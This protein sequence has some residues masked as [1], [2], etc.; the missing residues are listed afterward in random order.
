MTWD[1]NM[2]SLSMHTW[3]NFVHFLRFSCCVFSL[4]NMLACCVQHIF[5]Q[6]LT[7]TQWKNLFCDSWCVRWN[8]H[9]FLLPQRVLFTQNLQLF[10]NGHTLSCVSCNVITRNTQRHTEILNWCHMF[11]DACLGTMFWCAS[12]LWAHMKQ[13]C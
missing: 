11:I 12:R 10:C 7:V 5:Q 4:P 8:G 9:T 13:V 3:Y 6:C 1:N 2:V